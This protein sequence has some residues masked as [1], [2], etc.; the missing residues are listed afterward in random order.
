MTPK[1]LRMDGIQFT[2]FEI[3]WVGANPWNS[4][5]CFGSEDGRLLFS[6]TDLSEEQV[7]PQVAESGEAINGVAFS[8]GGRVA[9]STRSELVFL[10]MPLLENGQGSRVSYPGGSHDVITTLS[11]TFIAP[12]GI[13]GLLLMDPE[14][15]ASPAIKICRAREQDFYFYK[16]ACLGKRGNADVLACALRQDG[17]ASFIRDGNSGNLNVYSNI[18][19]D[20]VDVCSIGT[21]HYP[22]AVAAL[23]IDCSLHVIRNVLDP[24]DRWIWRFDRL[25]GVAYQVIRSGDHILI[26][27]SECLYAIPGLVTGFLDRLDDRFS[28]GHPRSGKSPL[29][30]VEIEAVDFYSVDDRWLFVI[31]PDGGARRIE[32]RDLVSPEMLKGVSDPSSE[33]SLTSWDTVSHHD[34][35]FAGSVS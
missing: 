3:S 27:T 29:T 7:L 6:K 20:V 5:L 33:T 17:W 10:S 32:I 13:N 25:R 9:V 11:K 24:R 26:L 19:L 22:Y 4:G 30:D 8:D 34:L 28:N 15:D 31:T 18:G 35:V 1:R 16:V 12:L 14:P 2:N 23:G 21:K